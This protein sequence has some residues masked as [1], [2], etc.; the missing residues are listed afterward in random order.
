[1]YKRRMGSQLDAMLGLCETV[2]CRRTRLLAY[3]G[4]S[5]TACG[6]CDVCLDPPQAWD[7]TVAAQK[8]LSA[9]YRLW[10][11]RGQRFGAGHVIDV[12]RGKRN[13]RVEQYRHDEL[14]VFGIGADLSERDWRGI[15][16]QL[17]A[18]S[19]L[20]VDHDGFS[21]LALTDGSR[22][23]LKGERTLM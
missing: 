23:V 12:L 8:V 11:E 14:S 19:L 20:T 21:T 1:Q 3:F 13:P 7:G 18:Q 22:A 4:Q 15:L 16:R 6:N 10:I 5:S 9:V 2:E 17:I